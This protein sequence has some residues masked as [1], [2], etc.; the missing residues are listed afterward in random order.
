MNKLTSKFYLVGIK[1]T[2]MSAL[3][4]CLKQMGFVVTGSDVN[5]S[6]FTD[7]ELIKKK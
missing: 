3:A 6:Y 2:G 1:G 4:I 5:K 7:K